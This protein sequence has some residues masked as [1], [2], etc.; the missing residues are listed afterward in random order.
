MRG[1]FERDRKRV[2][3]RNER[4][5]CAMTLGGMLSCKVLSTVASVIKHLY[6]TMW[7][8][9]IGEP[10]QN[11]VVW[12]DTECHCQEAEFLLQVSEIKLKSLRTLL[13]RDAY[14]TAGKSIAKNLAWTQQQW[15]TLHRQ[16]YVIRCSKE[17]A[18]GPS[19][20]VTPLPFCLSGPS[21]IINLWLDLSFSRK[22]RQEEYC[23]SCFYS[24]PPGNSLSR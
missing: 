13:N 20:P 15:F 2:L 14:T 9:T 24:L 19:L 3:H 23:S 8:I 22:Q 7:E 12:R 4:A 6:F 16:S 17:G 10:C 5:Y 11:S 1:K 21:I 18:G